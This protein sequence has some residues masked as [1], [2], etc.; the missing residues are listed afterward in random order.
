MN[1]S[2]DIGN[3][4]IKLA[5]YDGSL[6]VDFIKIKNEEDPELSLFLH[7]QNIQNVWVS[8]VRKNTDQLLNRL[9]IPKEYTIV[10]HDSQMPLTLEY[11][12]P[13]TLGVDRITACLGALNHFPG[14]HC[15]VVDLGTC[16]TIDILTADKRF[17]GGNISPG[18]KMRLDAMD[19]MTSK[20]PLGHLK[21]HDEIL[22]RSTAMAL[23]NGAFYGILF[24]LKGYISLMKDKYPE[25]KVIFTGGA[26][27]DFAELL[28]TEIFVLPFLILDGLNY[29]N[30]YCS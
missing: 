4:F 5:L 17:L 23:E 29:L 18:W 27:N 28:E 9:D 7:R 15:L 8:S 11:D 30:E 1:L 10:G 20:L 2:I 13:T 26:A 22:G 14:Q 19:Q 3:T 21:K 25:L 12:T 16:L 6:M 24:E